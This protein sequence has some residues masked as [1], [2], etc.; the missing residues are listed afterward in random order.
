MYAFVENWNYIKQNCLKIIETNNEIK[1]KIRN[2][3]V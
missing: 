2:F 1:S 3:K